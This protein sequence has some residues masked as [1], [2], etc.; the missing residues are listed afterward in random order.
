M[1]HTPSSIRPKSLAERIGITPTI[2]TVKNLEGVIIGAQGE[3]AHETV[4]IPACETSRDAER[5][6]VEARYLKEHGKS[7][8][9]VNP[10]FDILDYHEDDYLSSIEDSDDDAGVGPSR[11]NTPDSAPVSSSSAHMDIDPH[12]RSPSPIAPWI[13]AMPRSI[14]PDPAP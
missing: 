7:W 6:D 5:R 11:A 14:T 9:S 2:Q 12:A 8:N 1:H 4:E 13:F 10:G 3:R